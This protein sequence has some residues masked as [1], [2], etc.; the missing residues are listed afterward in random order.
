MDTRGTDKQNSFGSCLPQ[1]P[2]KGNSDPPA[3]GPGRAQAARGLLTRPAAMLTLVAAAS[4]LALPVQEAPN[5]ALQQVDEQVALKFTFN[6]SET[7]GN[8]WVGLVKFAPRTSRKQLLKDGTLS[9]AEVEETDDTCTTCKPF[10][11]SMENFYVSF[12][13]LMKDWHTFTLDTFEKLL[14]QISA[15][16]NQAICRIY[17]DYPG[18][19]KKP[20]DG[21]PGF[22][23]EG[24]TFWTSVNG[25]TPD[26]SN[27]TF[28]DAI[29]QLVEH[30]GKTYDGDN[31]LAVFQVG[32]L[33]EWGEWHQANSHALPQHEWYELQLRDEARW[34]QEHAA[35]D[36]LLAK[37]YA[38]LLTRPSASSADDSRSDNLG[39]DNSDDTVTGKRRLGASAKHSLIA[40]ASQPVVSVDDLASRGV[41]VAQ[42]LTV[43]GLDDEVVTAAQ[44]YNPELVQLA[45]HL[46]SEDRVNTAALLLN[47]LSRPI[48]V[49]TLGKSSD[50]TVSKQGEQANNEDTDPDDDAAALAYEI[51]KAED[52][53]VQAAR[54]RAVRAEAA[55][56]PSPTSPVG[57]CWIFEPSGCP[58]GDKG[59]PFTA[60]KRDWWGEKQ[61]QY[62]GDSGC[63]LRQ[64]HLRGWCGVND[65]TT[66]YVGAA[67]PPA[68]PQPAPS[69]PPD[70]CWVLKPSGCPKGDHT[71]PSNVWS[72]M[73][74]WAEKQSMYKGAAGC[75]LRGRHLNNWCGVTDVETHYN[76]ILAPPASPPPPFVLPTPPTQPLGSCWIIMPDGCPGGSKAGPQLTWSMDTWG[77]AQTQYQGSLGCML[78][79]EHL[80]SWCKVTSIKTHYVAYVG[81]PPSP[82]PPSPPP[83]PTTGVPFATPDVQ[84][85]LLLAFNASFSKTLLQVRYPN[86]LGGLDPSQLRI[87]WHDD[88]FDQDTY[89]AKPKW[90]K[91]AYTKPEPWLFMSRM[92]SAGALAR[93][94]SV[95]IGGEVRPEL[96]TCI[97]LPDAELPTACPWV[98]GRQPLP[99]DKCV[100]QTH[101]S[102]QWDHHMHMDDKQS[103][104]AYHEVGGMGYVYYLSELLVRPAATAESSD[105]G[106]QGADVDGAAAESFTIS[107]KIENRGVA[108]AYYDVSL[109]LQYPCGDS[110]I[111]YK[112]KGPLVSTLM[113]GQT[114]TVTSPIVMR[115]SGDACVKLSS[116]NAI[117]PIR[118]AVNE[119]DAKG[120]VHVKP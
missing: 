17:V 93:Y 1:F 110:G 114:M 78:R 91:G 32:I 61:P 56:P 67:V 92:E 82:P 21:V 18:M 13:S 98:G 41:L 54:E 19:T 102:F 11:T 83:T 118:W 90:W 103:P 39:D 29:V 108:P 119:Q 12:A 14:N 50:K 30:L 27:K 55:A 71:P 37:Q 88:S 62:Q 64:S 97:F 45:G 111:E 34:Y 57:S 20:T 4:F 36:P 96:Q 42:Q 69:S 58:K 70:S 63:A 40:R 46:S 79:E 68:P 117:K 77:M 107:A 2:S 116:P 25:V 51:F 99:F 16:G 33:G 35:G 95:P 28:I 120:R 106:T 24:L 72:G 22:L 31:R 87:G 6:Q 85:R 73:G 66:S 23:I 84:R 74:P 3:L 26:Y 52:P 109:K 59:G 60:W 75:A 115:T 53:E 43:N 100:Q 15:R 38:S 48:G 8:P 9:F 5:R 86:V 80:N 7:V 81:V 94:E 105:E 89:G 76:P 47:R 101:S 104:K 44:L 49:L 112:F 10:P 113:P 65:I